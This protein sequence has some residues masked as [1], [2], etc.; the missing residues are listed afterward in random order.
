MR[1][2]DTDRTRRGPPTDLGGVHME[3]D[4]LHCGDDST[5]IVG[6]T[7]VCDLCRE[8]EDCPHSVPSPDLR[9]PVPQG[10]HS[11]RGEC[12]LCGAR[13]AGH[14]WPDGELVD[15]EILEIPTPEVAR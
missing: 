13:V 3:A 7:P 5:E 9:Q 10:G 1:I 4:C 6:E 8:Y 12:E 2:P 14:E 15:V 11:I